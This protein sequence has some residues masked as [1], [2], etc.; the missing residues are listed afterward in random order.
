MEVEPVAY[1][2]D[3][4]PRFKG[5]LATMR[6]DCQGPKEADPEFGVRLQL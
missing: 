1:D 6:A 4:A 3:Y 2:H 5:A